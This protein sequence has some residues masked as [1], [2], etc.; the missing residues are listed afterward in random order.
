MWCDFIWLS[1]SPEGEITFEQDTKPET[2]HT[3]V[4]KVSELHHVNDSVRFY[5]SQNQGLNVN[6]SN[7]DD[8]PFIQMIKGW[9]EITTIWINLWNDFMKFWIVFR[10]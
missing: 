9:Q 10:K 5:D 7:N 1:K 6:P 4:Q 3:Q 8:K 2:N